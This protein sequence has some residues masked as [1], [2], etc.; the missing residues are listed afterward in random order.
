MKVIG[1]PE[2]AADPRF[3]TN[4]DRMSNLAALTPLIAERAARAHLGRLD[5]RVRGRGRSRGP[6]QHASATC[7]PTRRWPRA[8]W[9]S[10]SS[11]PRRPHEGARPADQVL[12]RRRAR[13]TRA[14]PTLGQH[15]REVLGGARLLRRRDRPRCA[16]TAPYR[17]LTGGVRSS[18]TRLGRGRCL[19]PAAPCVQWVH[20]R[21]HPPRARPIRIARLARWPR[22]PPSRAGPSAV[23]RGA[24]VARHR[25][26]S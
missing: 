14:A 15:T 24:L 21:D 20:G 6:G 16:P 8:R 22:A 18:Y 7:S 17:R 25:R 23:A 2:L 12:A 19:D 13:C 5:P 4:G 3:R 10:R 9:W 1:R 26:S 11:T